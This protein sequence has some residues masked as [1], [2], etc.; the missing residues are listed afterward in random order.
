LYTPKYAVSQGIGFI[1]GESAPY[2]AGSYQG[3]KKNFTGRHFRNR[4][5]FVS[6]AGTDEE[7]IREYIRSTE[8]DERLDQFSLVE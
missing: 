7:A 6:T 8:K 4:D 5:Y 1:K 3:H 2:I